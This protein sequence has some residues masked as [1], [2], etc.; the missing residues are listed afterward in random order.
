MIVRPQTQGKPYRNG[1]TLLKPSINRNLNSSKN[2]R[3]PD[4]N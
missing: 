3:T 1:A 4:R 2:S